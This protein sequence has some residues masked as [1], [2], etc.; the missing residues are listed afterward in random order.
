MRKVWIEPASRNHGIEPVTS[1]DA[2]GAGG[3]SLNRTTSAAI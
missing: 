3:V 1:R 2:A